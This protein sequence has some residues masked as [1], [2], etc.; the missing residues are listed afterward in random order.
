[1]PSTHSIKM[2][3]VGEGVVEAE[4]VNWHVKIGDL[5]EEDQDVVDVMTDKAT[6]EIPSPVTGKVLK[7]HGDPGDLIAVGSEI[8]VI[9]I[10]GEDEAPD[11]DEREAEAA[12]AETTD[13]TDP[14]SVT[15]NTAEDD[16]SE[17]AGITEPASATPAEAKSSASSYNPYDSLF[18][19]EDA[20]D[21]T[22]GHAVINDAPLASPAVRKRAVKL[23]MDLNTIPGSGPDGQITHEDLDARMATIKPAFSKTGSVHPTE[24]TDVKVIGLRRKIAQNMERAWQIPHIT[25][26][27]E[28]DVTEL[29]RLRQ[30]L[31][32]TRSSDQPK[33]TFI[34]FL[35]RAI[36]KAVQDLPQTNAHYFPDDDRLTQFDHVSLGIATATENGL[37]VPVIH[38]AQSMDV[39]AMAKDILEKSEAAR[40]GRAKK[41]DLTGSTITITSLGAVGGIVTTPILNPPETSIIGVNKMTD[42]LVQTANGTLETRKV[43]NLSSSFDHRIVDGFDAA[44]FIQKIKSLIEHPA[45]LFL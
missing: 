40:N 4:I 18:G 3:D 34:P 29:E 36:I 21:E 14:V 38:Q 26:V 12:E 17:P 20:S 16:A 44:M 42:K 5:V 19:E 24:G 32:T 9:E 28:I 27:E 33:L 6:V 1:M 23:G 7:V 22:G 30:H 39:W 41:D 43:M 15:A 31:N 13:D 25:Y 8:L 37:I 35:G 11:S 45:T 10:E 2:P